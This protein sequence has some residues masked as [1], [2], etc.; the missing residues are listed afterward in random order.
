MLA[1][2]NRGIAYWGCARE[3]GVQELLGGSDRKAWV[4]S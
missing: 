2:Y 4:A 1:Y 3:E